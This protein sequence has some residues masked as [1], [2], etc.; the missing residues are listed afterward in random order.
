[1]DQPYLKIIERKQI[2]DYEIK[3]Y[4]LVKLIV[5]EFIYQ[6]HDL[7]ER[8]KVIQPSLVF[9]YIKDEQEYQLIGE[10]PYDLDYI[11]IVFYPVNTINPFTHELPLLEIAEENRTHYQIGSDY[12]ECLHYK[13][14]PLFVRSGLVEVGGDAASLTP[15]ELTPYSV[16]DVPL[17]GDIKVVE[18]TGDAIGLNK[19]ELRS[20]EQGIMEK[21]LNFMGDNTN[22]TATEASFR[23]N[24]Q[25]ASYEVYINQKMSAIQEIFAIWLDWENMTLDGEA[26]AMDTS[27]LE[28]LSPDFIRELKELVTLNYLDLETFWVILNSAGALPKNVNIMDIINRIQSRYQTDL[29]NDE[30][31]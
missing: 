18:T 9:E 19:E 21:T 27:F 26:I 11:P 30:Q 20:I 17:Q 29:T 5:K 8:V 3:N 1:L 31:R 13:S 14:L 7:I 10:Y 28:S 15:L 25:K 24:Q 12:R 16:A 2:I 23:A 4:Q 6:G 22:M